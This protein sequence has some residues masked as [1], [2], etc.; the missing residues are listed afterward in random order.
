MGW[1]LLM[2]FV[3]VELIDERIDGSISL[4]PALAP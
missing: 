3:L 4:A 2:T 1:G